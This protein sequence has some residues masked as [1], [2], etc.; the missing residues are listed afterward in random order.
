MPTVSVTH[1]RPRY[2]SHRRYRFKCSTQPLRSN[3]SLFYDAVVYLLC[4]NLAAA[5]SFSNV[6]IFLL[7]IPFFGC[8]TLWIWAMEPMFQR[9]MLPPFSESSV[10]GSLFICIYKNLFRRRQGWG[11]TK[12]VKLHFS[13]W[14]LGR[15]TAR[16]Y[17]LPISIIWR[18]PLP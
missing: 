4:R 9:Y 12:E 3:S 13:W 6:T 2:G 17:R 11:R 16:K 14:V 18:I 15:V 1:R 8:Y 7:L 10:E 5:A